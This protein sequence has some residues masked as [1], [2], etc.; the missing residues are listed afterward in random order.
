MEQKRDLFI[1][2]VLFSAIAVTAGC[3]REENAGNISDS[4]GDSAKSGDAAMDSSQ[5]PAT[6]AGMDGDQDAVSD[7][8]SGTSEIDVVGSYTDTYGTSHA[9]TEDTWTQ[10]TDGGVSVFHITQYSNAERYLVAKGDSANE[11]NPSLWSRFDWIKKGDKLYYCQST[12]DASTEA[13]AVKAKPADS[14]D[15]DKGC[16][17]FSWSELID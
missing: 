13:E 10:N 7:A 5:N 8:N 3:G 16:G 14:S 12:Y 15:L 9:I 6:D 17:G 4:G 1:V 11:Y 2:V